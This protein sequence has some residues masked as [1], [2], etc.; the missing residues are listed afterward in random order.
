M[1]IIVSARL[2]D[3]QI[4]YK[5]I[6]L[7]NSD[8][9]DEIFL[10]RKTIGPEIPKV[11]YII[12]PS[13]S[14]I[15]MFNIL[16]T[17]F[18]L[19]YYTIKL[20]ADLIISYN[21]L[22]HGLFAYLASRVTGIPFNYSQIDTNTIEIVKKNTVKGKLIRRMIKKAIFI[23]VPGSNSV[24]FWKSQGVATDKIMTLHSTIDTE[25]DY[26]PIESKKVF[27]L[28]YIGVLEP[29][30]QVDIIVKSVKIL[31]EE[32]PRIRLAIVGDGSIKDEISDLVSTL[33]LTENIELFGHKTDVKSYIHKS[34]IFVMAS[35]VEG[36]P[37]AMMEA[38]ACKVYP[39]VPDV[40]DISDVVNGENGTLMPSSFTPEELAK[41]INEAINY[42][43]NIETKTS[44]ARQE[45]VDKHSYIS[46]KNAWDEILSKFFGRDSIRIS[47][48]K[49]K[50]SKAS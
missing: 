33:N 29:R 41:A 14:S 37:C 18:I 10:L 50:I 3:S 9:V 45:I 43:G 38:M 26:Y 46:A 20:K 5:I 16:F 17:P 11:K 8:M 30:K 48:S 27:D 47:G 49:L 39:I 19:A 24:K 35:K 31:T 6:P 2:K 36:I 42:A 23:N 32:H 25:N 1:K 7:S 40:A 22:P 44:R 12:L 4:K 13:L 21:F 28:L 15:K 34:K